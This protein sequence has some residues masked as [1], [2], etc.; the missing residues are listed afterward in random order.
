MFHFY[1]SI[2]VI[3]GL[4]LLISIPGLYLLGFYAHPA[5]WLQQKPTWL[6]SMVV[7]GVTIGLTWIGC[8]LAYRLGML[9]TF[10]GSILFLVSLLWLLYLL[11]RNRFSSTEQ[12]SLIQWK[13]LLPWVRTA[14]E[15]FSPVM[16]VLVLYC[17]WNLIV[18]HTP[19]PVSGQIKQWWGTL[20][21]TTYGS[22]LET[23]KDL[24][25][26]LFSGDSV[27]G[28]LMNLPL[29]QAIAAIGKKWY[30]EMLVWLLFAITGAG[31]WLLNRKNDSTEWT[32]ELGLLPFLAATMYRLVYFYI[33]GYVHMRSWYWTV[34]TFF[35]FLLLI[36]LLWGIGF[37]ANPSRWRKAF[38]AGLILL[39]GIVMV[40]G[41]VKNILRVYPNNQAARENRDYLVVPEM[42]AAATHP[43]AVIGT[44]GGGSL[45]YFIQDRTIL[46]L[47][48]L[49]NSKEYFDALKRFDTRE[50]MQTSKLEYVFGNEN[51][52][53]KSSPYTR[54]FEGCLD[55]LAT[56]IWE[57]HLLVPVQIRRE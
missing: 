41:W 3:T 52:L 56:G 35:G 14:V 19:M 29:L 25:T 47:D 49:M 26:Y 16:T 51:T 43:G 1:R 23:W 17:G 28:Y 6:R 55:P 4:I 13:A 40:T 15:Y 36:S 44:P 21:Q 33:S 38:V 53:F 42:V 18:F 45:S 37:T 8:F 5:R 46:N 2:L 10:S 22:P 31:I 50:I 30:G 9:E 57:N 39:W 12:G 11:L 54:I 27:F 32:D 20:G 34:E 48:G 7:W 24:Q